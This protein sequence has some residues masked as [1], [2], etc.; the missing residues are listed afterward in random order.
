MMSDALLM[1]FVLAIVVYLWVVQPV[2]WFRNG[3]KGH[4]PLPW[5]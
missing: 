2:R 1:G 5:I 3:C 4:F